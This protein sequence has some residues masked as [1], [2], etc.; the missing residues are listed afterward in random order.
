MLKS[1]YGNLLE[2]PVSIMVVLCICFISPLLF[3]SRVLVGPS[4]E[5]SALFLIIFV[6][7]LFHFYSGILLLN[8]SA[9]FFIV[10]FCSGFFISFS[11]LMHHPYGTENWIVYLIGSIF[12]LAIILIIFLYIKKSTKVKAYFE[13]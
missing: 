2:M 4:I 11:P 1:F 6:S 5:H 7:F 13:A 12:N 8:K 9:R 10:F 3:I